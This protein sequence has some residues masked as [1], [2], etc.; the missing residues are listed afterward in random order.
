MTAAVALRPE[1]APDRI[2]YAAYG[3]NMAAGRLGVYL[4]GGRPVGGLRDYPGARDRTPP[5]R[6]EPV[7]LPGTV[8]FALESRVWG[9]G[10]AFYDPDA[11]GQTPARAYLMTAG[12]FSDLAAQEMHRAPGDD[13]DLVD[14]LRSGRHRYGP[15]RYETLVHVGERDGW[16]MLTLTAPWHLVDV[17][18]TAPSA[19]YLRM[20]AAGLREAHGWTVEQVAEHLAGLPGARGVWTAGRVAEAIG[21]PA[22]SSAR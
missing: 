22:A 5:V 14:A 3:S 21:T 10:M 6:D 4:A 13:L 19:A 16:P 12:Q 11:D 18:L 8:Y 15:G 1:P 9:G 20:L 7:W 17:T 2:W